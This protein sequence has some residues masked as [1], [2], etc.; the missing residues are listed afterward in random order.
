MET[1]QDME[2]LV[3]RTDRRLNRKHLFRHAALTPSFESWVLICLRGAA[4]SF[5]FNNCILRSEI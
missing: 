2:Y 5:L 1:P 4:L 3:T